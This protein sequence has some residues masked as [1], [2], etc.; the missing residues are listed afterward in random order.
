MNLYACRLPGSDKREIYVADSFSLLEENLQEIGFVF[1]PFLNPGEAYLI[2]AHLAVERIPDQIIKANSQNLSDIRIDDK[3]EYSRYVEHIIQS[4]GENENHK[5]VA[6][7]RLR[8]PLDIPAEK[9]FDRLSAKYPDAFVFLFSTAET[10]TWIGA[11]PELLLERKGETFR[12][13]ALAGTRSAATS[14]DWDYKNLREQEIVKDFLEDILKNRELKVT[15]DETTTQKAG[16]VEHLMTRIKAHG[17][18]KYGVVELLKTMSPTP[19]LCGYPKES[20]LR[21][22]VEHEGDGRGFYGGYAGIWHGEYDFKLYVNLRSG[23][24][25][26]NE[27]ILSAGGGIT[28]HSVAEEEWEE[29]EKKLRTLIDVL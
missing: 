28:R 25:E 20:A 22:I 2:P 15:V 23:K 26:K 21:T 10:G 4:L 14:G 24:I 18:L 11:S 9:L 17:K 27:I 19:A 7:R 1:A 6:S 16:P 5:V 29:T 3:E 8:V 13:M 12:T